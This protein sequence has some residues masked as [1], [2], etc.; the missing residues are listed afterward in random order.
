MD[1]LAWLLD[2]PSSRPGQV[3]LQNAA[4]FP[5]VIAGRSAGTVRLPAGSKVKVVC[6][7][8]GTLTVAHNGVSITIAPEATDLRESATKAMAA[9]EHGKTL[10]PAT[11]APTTPSPTPPP[12][13][14]IAIAAKAFLHP[15]MLHNE[16]DFDRMRRSRAREPWKS[17]LERLLASRHGRLD[18]QPAPEEIVVR[19][20]GRDVLLPEN[21]GK[22]YRD[23]AAAYACALRWKVTRERDY[24]EKAVEILDAWSS[25]LKKITGSSDAALAAGFSGYQFANAAEILRT[26]R[27]WTPENFDRFKAMM[28]EVF[29]PINE[30][31]L[32]RHN[33]TKIDHYWA[34]WDLC[35]MASLM[36]IGI[37]C[38]DRSLYDKAVRY[39]KHGKGNGA[40]KN[41]VY[42]VHPGGL[43][44]W[45]EAGRDQGHATLGIPLMATICEMAWK[46][47]DDL[48]GYDNNRFLA[49][50][51]YVAKYNLGEEVP[52]K[53][54]VN[55]SHGTQQTISE[56]GRGQLRPGW[57]L[58]FNHYVVRKRLPAPYTEQMAAKIRPEGGGGDYGPNSGGYDQ[59]GYGTLTATLDPNS[60]NA[61][62]QHQK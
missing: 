31:F 40:I 19:G 47:G 51:E 37:L 50:C 24:A 4:E 44:Q 62:V 33:G 58:V 59:L 22:L 23:A 28:R 54:Y 1:P 46:Q 39:F 17:G 52:F 49:G 55:S 42:Y 9:T 36:A 21:Y 5:I 60:E 32:E 18:W 15:G 43:G 25:T 57:E 26:Y 48:Y 16:E 35:N 34:N 38:D 61:P 6:F 20:T 13:D 12:T 8:P 11:P 7:E 27:G 10:R 56:V 14:E 29:L 3:T 30:D 53:T 45:Q 2:N 41:A